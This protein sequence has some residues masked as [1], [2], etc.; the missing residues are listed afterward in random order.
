MSVVYS[1]YFCNEL[2]AQEL[3]KSPNLVTLVTQ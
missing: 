2:C 1:G 3:Q